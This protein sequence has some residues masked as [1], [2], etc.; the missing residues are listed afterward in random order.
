MRTAEIEYYLELKMLSPR[1]IQ[2]TELEYK[3]K[4]KKDERRDVRVCH[5]HHHHHP[6][7]VNL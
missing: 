5:H 4:G 3:T 7:L 1:T 2:P 6:H